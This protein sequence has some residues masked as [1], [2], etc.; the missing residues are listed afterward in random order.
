MR[1][2]DELLA[3]ERV[4]QHAGLLEAHLDQPRCGHGRAHAV[5]VDEHDTRAPGGDE[6]VG[7]LHQLHALGPKCAGEMAGLV[8]PPLAHIEEV[9]RALVFLR[10]PVGK[11][12]VV[13]LLDA[14]APCHA[15]SQGI[16]LREALSA[17]L[18]GAALAPVLELEAG[19]MP[20]HGA[21]PERHHLVRHL[22][23][24]QRLGADDAARAPGAV[25]DDEGIGRRRQV[26]GPVDELRARAI[27]GAGDVHPPELGQGPGVEDDEVGPGLEHVLELH[28]RDRRRV[29]GA[30]DE[31][32]EGLALD[33]DAG[34]ELV[35]GLGPGLHPAFENTDIGISKAFEALRRAARQ[36]VRSI[37]EHD[38]RALARHHVANQQLE[39]T[40]RQVRGREQVPVGERAL[41]ADIQQGEL[42]LASQHLLELI[43]TDRPGHQPS[44]EKT[45]RVTESSAI[46][47]RSLCF[48]ANNHTGP[49]NRVQGRPS[50]SSRFFLT[51]AGLSALPC[52]SRRSPRV[53]SFDHNGVRGR[54]TVPTPPQPAPHGTDECIFWPVLC[55][56]RMVKTL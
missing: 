55:E 23:V 38:G 51:L 43:W 9:E 7:L 42:A 44:P 1:T 15:F 52:G 45:S 6:G 25:D 26:M 10:A 18:P 32:A 2:A 29:A 5:I 19:E 39:G 53:R 36:A 11:G 49:G 50:R 56:A 33:V 8:F 27:D 21:V 24:D 22:G 48:P 16:G 31:F 35:P 28:R 17:H 4:F 41:F 14:E 34:E 3:R 13:D 37:R 46:P 12:R 30:L 54:D 40:E 47:C 20:T